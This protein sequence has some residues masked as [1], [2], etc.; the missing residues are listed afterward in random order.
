M[1]LFQAMQISASGLQAQRLRMNLLANNLANANSTRTPQGGPYRR[2]DVFFRSVDLEDMTGQRNPIRPASFESEL[3]RHLKGVRVS[4]IVRD[5]R[6]PRTLYDPSHPDANKDGYVAMPNVNIIG[7]MVSMM[8]ATRSYEAGVTS[9][10][11]V[12][13]MINKALTIGR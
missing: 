5:T 9:I 12:K 2:K 7:E 3:E 8:N 4:R 6:P 1:D 13:A 10:N 11:A